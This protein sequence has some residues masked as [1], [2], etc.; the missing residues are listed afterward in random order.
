MKAFCIMKN[1]KKVAAESSFVINIVHF[2][3]HKKAVK[4][5]LEK[6]RKREKLKIIIGASG[7]NQQGWITTERITL[8]LLDPKKWLKLI[9]KHSISNILAEHVFEHLT[10]NE[11]QKGIET[12]LMFLKKGGTM[13]IAVPDSYHPSKE[14]HEY[15]KPGGYGAGARDHKE[16]Y[17][18]QKVGELVSPFNNFI[19]ISFLEYYDE[20][21]KLHS[22]DID[23]EKGKIERTIKAGRRINGTNDIYS[24]LIFDIILKKEFDKK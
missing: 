8:D 23:K 17:N 9:D 7:T 2:I 15:S 20:E 22:K 16:F 14:Y 12:C 18:Y 21:G 24:S 3:R 4:K 11:G 1:I 10:E 6:K 13:R 19:Q 5:I